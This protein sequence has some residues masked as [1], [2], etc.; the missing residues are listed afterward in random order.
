M[1]WI[2]R[3]GDEHGQNIGQKISSSLFALLCRQLVPIGQPDAVPPQL[4]HQS[5]ECLALLPEHAEHPRA[6]VPQQLL[7]PSPR[8]LCKSFE[9][10]DPLHE[11]LI[12]VR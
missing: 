9:K 2:E 4:D 5:G 1:R 6:N 10:L 7:R 12:E 3:Q 8:V 11:E